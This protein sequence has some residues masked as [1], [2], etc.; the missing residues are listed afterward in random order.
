MAMYP[1]GTL[2]KEHLDVP[3]DGTL[4][5]LL[6]LWYPEGTLRQ[7][8]SKV[9]LRQGTSKVP[10]LRYPRGALGMKVP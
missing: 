6:F 10:C 5:V 7:G 9:P 3:R 8:T 1:G 4:R 2:I